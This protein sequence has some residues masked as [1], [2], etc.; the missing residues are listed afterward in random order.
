MFVE[1][2]WHTAHTGGS[3]ESLRFY[4][5]A[6]GKNI[7]GKQNCRIGGTS[8]YSNLIVSTGLHGYRFQRNP[9]PDSEDLNGEAIPYREPNQSQSMICSLSENK[10]FWLVFY[11]GSQR[12]ET[13]GRRASPSQT[14]IDACPSG[15]RG[16]QPAVGNGEDAKKLQAC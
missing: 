8:L 11:S 2:N 7:L 5:P 12:N 10:A 1:L 13:G 16:A 3:V 15:K 14:D 9:R 6:G 4:S